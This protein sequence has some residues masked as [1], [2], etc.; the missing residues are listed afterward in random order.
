MHLHE[1]VPSPLNLIH[2]AYT[3][4]TDGPGAL[5]LDGTAIAGLPD[6]TVPLAEVNRLLHTRGTTDATKDAAWAHLVNA[7][8][9]QATPWTTICA[10]LAL[11][12]LRNAYRK[13]RWTAP[14]F[15]D[16]ADLAAA[17]VE[18][19]IAALADIDLHRP[20]I[21]RRLCNSAYTGVRA[22][23]RELAQYQQALISNEYESRPP[24]PQHGHIDLVLDKAVTDG[25]LTETQVEL[26]WETYIN[27]KP[28]NDYATELN[29][30]PGTITR[31]RRKA[32]KALTEWLTTQGIP[33]PSGEEPLK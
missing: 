2:V 30:T 4:L 10:G 16:R 31:R 22:Y 9:A 13:A 3:E 24:K 1:N 27:D 23:A 14:D 21:A 12:G 25:A 28:V 8:R 26:I 15:I 18:A 33:I 11:P 17:T 6:R 32:K 7:A 5:A 19:F 20:R 29:L